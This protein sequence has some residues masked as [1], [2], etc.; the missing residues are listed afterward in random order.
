[1]KLALITLLMGCSIASHAA[2]CPD[3]VSWKRRLLEQLNALRADGGVC[4]DGAHFSA[5][6]EPLR[7]SDA[8]E[9]AAASQTHFMAERGELLHVG[10]RGEGIG[11]R[12]RQAA[13]AFER[14]GE[15]VGMGFFQ[16]DQVV[17]AW[18]ASAKHC[19]NL[20]D[21][22]F[23]EVG[24]ACLKSSNGPWWTIIVGRPQSDSPSRP[25]MQTVSWQP[26]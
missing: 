5:A 13:Y 26:R 12:A 4:S 7:W 6:V 17:T 15:N 2:A 24:L 16:M 11:E 9:S 22:R 19:S 14:V 18:R 1:M 10:R 3:D 21:P 20:L 8:L 23:T 25:R